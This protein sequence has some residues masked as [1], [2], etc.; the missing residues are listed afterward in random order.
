[1]KTCTD[2]AES[3]FSPELVW[4]APVMADSD[5]DEIS[6]DWELAHFGALDLAGKDTDCDGNGI[7]DLTEFITGTNP[8]DPADAPNLTVDGDRKLKF[9]ARKAA[10]EGYQNRTRSY[11]L[12][13]CSDLV[14]GQWTPV[15]GMQ[16][17]SA[18]D[19]VVSYDILANGPQG[20]YRTDVRLN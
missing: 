7:C 1:M 20:Y 17:I 5:G 3:D 18:A 8:A 15:P 16:E 11:S 6:D 4:S 2:Q 14:S 10:G 13:Y 9:I 19:Q 12:M